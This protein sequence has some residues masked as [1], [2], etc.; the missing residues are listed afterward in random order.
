MEI[1]ESS[2][3]DC[4]KQ[5]RLFC[6]VFNAVGEQVEVELF[7]PQLPLVCLDVERLDGSENAGCHNDDCRNDK[8][9]E[10]R[11]RNETQKSPDSSPVEIARVANDETPNVDND[12]NVNIN[13]YEI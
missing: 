9:N 5:H 4:R 6:V 7:F 13:D 3:T 11:R 10:E 12:A 1:S 8:D 2:H